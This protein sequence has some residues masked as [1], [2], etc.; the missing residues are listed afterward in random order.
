MN[1][2]LI[3]IVPVAL[4]AG[5]MLLTA[6]GQAGD[7]VQAGAT[8]KT[9]QSASGNTGK[10]AKT[11]GV[12][13]DGSGEAVECVDCGTV[14]IHSYEQMLVAD[15]TPYG[16]VGCTEAFNVISQYLDAEGTPENW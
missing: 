12:V 15:G 7:R 9:S 2:R 3:A 13:A 14:E 10:P 16:R 11:D 8:A 1:K 4:A 6:C 5:V